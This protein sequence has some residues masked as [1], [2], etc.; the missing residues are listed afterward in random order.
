MLIYKP[1]P[2]NPYSHADWLRLVSELIDDIARWSVEEE[3]SVHRYTK[4]MI[5]DGG[6]YHAPA[7]R[8]RLP[9]GEIRVDPIARN[10][11]GHGA[12]GRVNVEA[13]PSTE[14]YVLILRDGYWDART[15]AVHPITRKWDKKTFVQMSRELAL[16]EWIDPTK[17]DTPTDW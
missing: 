11:G 16:T 10:I 1:K 17:A 8:V 15:D 4:R 3:W 14:R 5:E 12:H 2:P 9:E 6:Q 7:L 13:W